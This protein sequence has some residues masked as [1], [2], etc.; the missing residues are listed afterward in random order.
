[1]AMAVPVNEF[2]TS[3]EMYPSPGSFSERSSMILSNNGMAELPAADCGTEPESIAAPEVQESVK[4]FLIAATASLR[5]AMEQLE[6][7]EEKILFVVDECLRVAGS[8]TDGDIRRWILSDGNLK[9]E[10]YCACNCSPYTVGVGFDPERVRT[11]ML[12]RNITCVPV[13][14]SRREIVRLLFWN[15]LFHQE[16][17]PRTRPRLSLPVVIM[18]GGRGTRLAPFTNVLPKPLIP[19]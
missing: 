5:Q 19:V 2:A 8:L 1:M 17:E 4:S 18:A 7:T 9:S 12:A 14:T 16:I 6:R 11:E 3:S 13:L 15:D 10:V